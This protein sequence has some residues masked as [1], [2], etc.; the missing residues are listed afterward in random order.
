MTK[1]SYT[2]TIEDAIDDPTLLE[3]SKQLDNILIKPVNECE[4]KSH[5]RPRC[6]MYMFICNDPVL[7]RNYLKVRED[8]GVLNKRRKHLFVTF[9]PE[10]KDHVYT[11]EEF[12][13]HAH[14][15]L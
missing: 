15:C 2:V 4:S 6:L 11:M 9:N 12:Q 13:Y 1:S 5:F 14:T 3:I 10:M 7:L 8:N